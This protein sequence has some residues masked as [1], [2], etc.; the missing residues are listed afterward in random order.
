MR[1]ALVAAST[2][3]S[4]ALVAASAYA[5]SPADEKAADALFQSARAAMDRGDLASACERFAESQRLDP[6]PGTLLNL[7]ECEARTG[8]LAAALTHYREGRSG[9]PASDFR[10]SFTDRRIEELASRVPRFMVR[11]SSTAQ[12]AP[13]LVVSCDG[14]AI[15]PQALGVEETVNPGPHVCVVTAK[16]HAARRVEFT[17]VEGERRTLDLE[18]GPADAPESPTQ[19]RESAPQPP[20]PP[21]PVPVPTAPEQVARSSGSAQ[22]IAGFV[23][24][25]AGVAGLAVG[26]VFGLLAKHSY[27]SATATCGTVPTNCTSQGVDDGATAYAQ[28]TVSTAA[29]IAGGTLLA[30]GLVIALTAP[31]SGHL[32]AVP[33]IGANG[34]GLS[35]RGVW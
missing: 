22:R 9:L 26:G 7:G 29:F 4:V 5:V 10:I 30:G 6:A 20:P 18:L 33:A 21:R 8:K 27:D 2:Y 17:V 23:V 28:A 15:T 35:I 19:A 11:P 31:K 14:A 12:S 24:V 32:E 3:A 25:G 13:G 16:G 34:A 1:C